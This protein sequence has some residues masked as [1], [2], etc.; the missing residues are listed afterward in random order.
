MSL[1]SS[2]HSQGFERR[3]SQAGGRCLRYFTSDSTLD[4]RTD[5]LLRSDQST[6]R[7]YSII[8]FDFECT[9]WNS[10]TDCLQMLLLQMVGWVVIRSPDVPLPLSHPATVLP[11]ARR[12]IEAA[13]RQHSMEYTSTN[14]NRA[15]LSSKWI[16]SSMMMILLAIILEKIRGEIFSF[17]LATFKIHVLGSSPQQ[18]PIIPDHSIRIARHR[19]RKKIE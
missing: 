18:R 10:V 14:Q 15:A 4:K 16:S 13:I 17:F 2:S 6:F 5:V 1:S 11:R 9:R 8:S 7:A 3:K 19:N 12:W